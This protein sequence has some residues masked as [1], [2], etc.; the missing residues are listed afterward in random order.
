MQNDFGSVCNSFKTSLAN[1]DVCY[2]IL[3]TLWTLGET[4]KMVGE[5]WFNLRN[6]TKGRDS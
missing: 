5:T 2:S 1:V 4:G 3:A 6:D